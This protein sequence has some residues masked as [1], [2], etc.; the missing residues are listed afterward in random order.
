MTPTPIRSPRKPGN[1]RLSA[2]PM[3]RGLTRPRPPSP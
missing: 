2:Q 1:A 3:R